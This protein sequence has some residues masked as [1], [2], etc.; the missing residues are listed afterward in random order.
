MSTDSPPA[1]DATPDPLSAS[2]D[3]LG[4]PAAQ[5]TYLKGRWL[6]QLNWFEKKSASN[7]RTHRRLRIVALVGGVISP[8]LINAAINGDIAWLEVSAVVVSVIVGIAVALEGFLRPGDRWLQ[9]RQTAELLRTEWWLYVSLAG[10]YVGFATITDGHQHF[11]D[12]I[13]T[14][15]SQDVTGFVALVA[16]TVEVPNSKV[17][18][19][20]G[21][22]GG[23]PG[24]T[25]P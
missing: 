11:V 8:V 13:E 19:P 16:P 15:V 24:E 17:P 3:A 21:A 10:E 5:T 1:S 2:I 25:A 6:D 20:D 4:L 22:I 23:E 18:P 14:I 12:R 7:Q 9:Y